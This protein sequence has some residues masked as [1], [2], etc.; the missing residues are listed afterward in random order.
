MFSPFAQLLLKSQISHR[1]LAEADPGSVSIQL[2]GWSQ[3][4]HGYIGLLANYITKGWRRAKL[5]LAC[6]PFEMSH[7][8]ENLARWKEWEEYLTKKKETEGIES[9]D[10]EDIIE[11][12][13]TENLG[14]PIFNLRTHK[15]R[16][17]FF[18]KIFQT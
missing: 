4:H 14:V 18:N 6:R 10:L 1:K 11:E 16:N 13:E 17:F 12:D 7:T 5:C 3:H 8:G 9:A 2:D 15:K